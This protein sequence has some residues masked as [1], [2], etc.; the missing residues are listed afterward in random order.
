MKK[1]STQELQS[2]KKH[3]TYKKNAIINVL[4]TLKA[5]TRQ[6]HV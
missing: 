4:S 1:A 3:E 5:L 2:R 6:K